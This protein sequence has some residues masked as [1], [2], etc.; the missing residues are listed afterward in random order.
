[1]RYGSNTSDYVWL[2][3]WLA[4]LG[5]LGAFLCH[6]SMI[7]FPCA[8][9]QDC[10]QLGTGIDCAQLGKLTGVDCAQ[11]GT[12]IDCTQ[13]GTGI[14]CA[15]LGAGIHRLGSPPEEAEGR[16]GGALGML[17]VLRVCTRDLLTALVYRV[18]VRA[19]R[20]GPGGWLTGFHIIA[21]G[22]GV[23]ALLQRLLDF[24]DSFQ[25]HVIA[26]RYSGVMGVTHTGME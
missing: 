18:R 12:G 24:S 2:A 16:C 5:S 10:A 21:T 6:V 3:L 7:L 1:M 4:Y 8:H 11:L 14:D 23:A 15:Q 9:C 13:L 20:P 22:A 19:C 25:A 26:G 17:E